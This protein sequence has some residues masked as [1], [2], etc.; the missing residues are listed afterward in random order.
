[1]SEGHRLKDFQ[2]W[3]N[4][5]KQRLEDE[6]KKVR[7]DIASAKS[8]IDDWDAAQETIQRLEQE[9]SYLYA[10]LSSCSVGPD[11]SPEQQNAA[12]RRMQAIQTEIARINQERSYQSSR[13][14]SIRNDMRMSQR[15]FQNSS[16]F[17]ALGSCMEENEKKRS[18]MAA[19]QSVVE[20]ADA[21]ISS[22][23]NSNSK[24]ISYIPNNITIQKD[25]IAELKA[26][27]S[28]LREDAKTII[29]CYQAIVSITAE[30]SSRIGDAD[31]QIE[32]GSK[33]L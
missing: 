22:A 25:Q 13:L 2:S 12:S 19:Y 5:Y 7:G 17:S 21:V 3:I 6:L 11:S 23:W 28:N 30:I 10:Q 16:Y 24:Y 14:D 15:M 20:Q 4:L 9:I 1:M 33:R 8:D 29:Q 31:A 18:E 32:I 27:Q 26:M